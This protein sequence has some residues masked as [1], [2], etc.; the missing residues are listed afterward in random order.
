M[1][2]SSRLDCGKAVIGIAS[3]RHQVNAVVEGPG[4][5]CQLKDQLFCPSHAQVEV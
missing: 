3:R 4:G 5:G 2:I 1:Q